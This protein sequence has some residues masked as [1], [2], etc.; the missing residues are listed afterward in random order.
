[1]LP[2]LSHVS[3]WLAALAA[4]ASLFTSGR[5]GSM[6]AAVALAA[7]GAAL[8]LRRYRPA[9]EAPEL[10]EALALDDAAMLDVGAILSH[11]VA[12]ADTLDAALQELREELIH[13]LGARGVTIHWM[14]ATPEMAAR[15]ADRFPLCEALRTGESAG[16][17]AG[18]FAMPV[19][20]GGRIVAM[21]TFKGTELG[22]SAPALIRLL[23]LVRVQ[24][25]GL[26]LRG[27]Q[28]RPPTARPAP[29]LRQPNRPRTH[30]RSAMKANC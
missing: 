20:R 4:A 3:L 13:E 26:A 27:P 28:P 22:V 8:W 11:S 25:D 17:L 1:M 19:A 5:Q 23:E 30:R 16:S 10:A 15:I 29:S 9:F 14:D 18:G 12:R 2:H 7:L 6:L 21:L 24:V